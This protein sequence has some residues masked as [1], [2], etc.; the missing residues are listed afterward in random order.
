MSSLARRT[1]KK[2]TQRTVASSRALLGVPEGS[3]L[4]D[5]PAPGHVTACTSWVVVPRR[6]ARS[7]SARSRA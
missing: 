3:P 6:D 4:H 5:G 7:A 2:L 1:A